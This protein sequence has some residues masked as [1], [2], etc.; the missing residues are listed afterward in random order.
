[1]RISW[2]KLNNYPELLIAA[3][4]KGIEYERH[5]NYIDYVL[6]NFIRV[7]YRRFICT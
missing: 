6:D 5:Q 4:L 1:M 7:A 3:L 2:V